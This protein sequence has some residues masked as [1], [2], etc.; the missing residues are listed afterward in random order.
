MSPPRTNSYNE[1]LNIIESYLSSNKQASELAELS[2][3]E[4]TLSGEELIGLLN[5]LEK[6]KKGKLKEMEVKLQ[7]SEQEYQELNDDYK[8]LSL[9]YSALEDYVNQ[10]KPL[11][12]TIVSIVEKT[13]NKRVSELIEKL[14]EKHK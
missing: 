12:D 13:A 8:N 3:L 1:L 9:S 4:K 2:L 5:N 6:L 7:E 11:I 10:Y 14:Q